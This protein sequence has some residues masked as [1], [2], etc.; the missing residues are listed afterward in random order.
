MVSKAFSSSLEFQ[1]KA[2]ITFL[3]WITCWSCYLLGQST[4]NVFFSHQHQSL[5][6]KGIDMDCVKK[7][8]QKIKLKTERLIWWAE[9]LIRS[10]CPSNTGKEK[11]LLICGCLEILGNV[12][13]KNRLPFGFI[14]C[15]EGCRFFIVEGAW[16]YHLG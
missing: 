15:K 10:H 4:I 8:S 14:L 11:G 12:N 6:S 9:R 16:K 1:W 3:S 7:V 2:K 13:F 5:C